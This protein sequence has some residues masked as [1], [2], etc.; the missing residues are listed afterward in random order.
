MKFRLAKLQFSPEQEAAYRKSVLAGILQVLRV[1]GI[2]GMIAIPSFVMNDIMFDPDAAERTLPIRIAIAAAI[3]CTLLVFQVRRFSES[4]RF[5][6]LNI[7]GLFIFF[8]FALVLIQDSHSNGF[9][10]NVPGYIQV[11]VFIPLVAFSFLQ[12]A[13]ITISIVFIAVL[14]AHLSNA[15]EIEA[16]N[17]LNWLSGSAAFAL[18]AAFV[19]DAARRRT[20]VLEQDLMYEKARS[21]ELLLNVLPARIAERLKNKEPRISDYC[22][23]ATVLFADIAGF[24][25]FSRK[26][27]PG[28]VVDLLNDL[29]SRFDRL[30]EKHG[31]EKIKTIGD[32]YMCAAGLTDGADAEEAAQSVVSLALDMNKTFY[33]FQKTRAPDLGLRIGLHSG[34]VVAGVIG[35]GKFSFDL[36]GDTVNVSSR[37]E[38]ACPLDCILMTKQTYD[39]IG[40]RYVATPKG[41]I[42]I[43]GHERREVFLLETSKTGAAV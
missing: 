31:V 27:E 7:Y 24:T 35:T 5:V 43:I 11:M 9:V 33:E 32:G 13:G 18:G 20:F 41:D 22:P 2:A 16:A 26:L 21:D 14:G 29:F 12:A 3:G 15:T 6:A 10:V 39:L 8:S 19:V 38:G 40:D 4:P 1:G 28:E 17:Q 34:P 37:I 25:K 36:W 42:E 30:A 23:H